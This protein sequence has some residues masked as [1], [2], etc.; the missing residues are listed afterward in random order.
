MAKSPES[1]RLEPAKEHEHPREGVTEAGRAAAPA[2]AR[3]ATGT[4]AYE[5]V[6]LRLDDILRIPVHQGPAGPVGPP[7]HP[8]PAGPPGPAGR[9]GA[10]G[11]VG[12]AGPPGPVGPAGPPGKEGNIG[13]VGAIGPMG[14]PGPMGPPGLPGQN[15]AQGPAGPPGPTIVSWHIDRERYRAIPILS[16]GLP[17]PELNLWP[18]FEPLFQQ[19]NVRLTR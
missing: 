2:A 6:R 10:P 14:A 7:G 5:N 12:P 16:D 9:D 13:Y 19:G 3:T 17:G 1:D 18:L 11:H 4:T 8:G 15:G